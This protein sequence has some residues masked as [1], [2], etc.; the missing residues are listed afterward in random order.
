MY[1][2]FCGAAGILR[3]PV[4]P[5]GKEASFNSTARNQFRGSVPVHSHLD[6]Q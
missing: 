2:L 3:T 6:T 1:T 5:L 4:M